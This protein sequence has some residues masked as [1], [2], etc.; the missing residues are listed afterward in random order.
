[1]AKSV[2]LLTACINPNGM[3]NTALQDAGIRKAQYL[4]AIDFYLNETKCNIVFCENTETD[5]FDEVSSPEK[6]KRMETLVFRGNDYNKSRGKAYGEAKIIEYAIRHSEFIGDA[7]CVCKITGRVKILNINDIL[8]RDDRKWAERA[9]IKAHLLWR[10]YMNSVCY[11]ASKDWLLK[12]METFAEQLNEENGCD[13][14]DMLYNAMLNTE[15][16]KILT[17]LPAIDGISGTHNMLYGNIDG[18]VY[19]RCAD[20][21]LNHYGILRD[22]YKIQKERWNYMVTTLMWI[23]CVVKWKW[24]MLRNK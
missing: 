16:V 4:D 19:A 8:I 12:T 15:N 13:M 14:S 20:M 11:V 6:Y 18:G 1:M 10:G 24:N 5:L 22:V 21:R 2:I 3:A 23:C 9:T 17:C 7:N